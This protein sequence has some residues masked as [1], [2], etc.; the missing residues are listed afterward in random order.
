MGC[1]VCVC[2]GVTGGEEV[3]V[4]LVLFVCVWLVSWFV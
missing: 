2:D 4:W 1:V 3:G